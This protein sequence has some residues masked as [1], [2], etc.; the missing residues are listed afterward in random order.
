[1]SSNINLILVLGA[2][3]CIGYLAAH[4]RYRRGRAAPRAK[5]KIPRVLSGRATDDY[6]MVLIVRNDL[7]LGKG[8]ACAQ[9]AHGATSMYHKLLEEQQYQLIE[10][11]FDSGQKKVVVKVRIT[12]V[13]SGYSRAVSIEHA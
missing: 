2:G 13:E 8:K 10:N 6:K 5:D 4:I 11:W 3:V 9:C 7:H 12:V 1:M